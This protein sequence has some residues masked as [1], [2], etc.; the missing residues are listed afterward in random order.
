M[1]V[2]CARTQVFDRDGLW[3]IMVAQSAPVVRRMKPQASMAQVNSPYVTIAHSLGR[4][5]RQPPLSFS[6]CPSLF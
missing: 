2:W 3:A 5:V 4:L 6:S 1:A